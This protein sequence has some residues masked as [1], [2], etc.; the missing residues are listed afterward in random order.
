MTKELIVDGAPVK[1]TLVSKNL[2]NICL[3]FLVLFDCVIVDRCW[4]CRSVSYYYYAE[5]IQEKVHSF[6][7]NTDFMS[8]RL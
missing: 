6:V 7:S 8:L 3:H 1:V 4:L 2:K 5:E